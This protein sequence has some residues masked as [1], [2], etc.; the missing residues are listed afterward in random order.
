MPHVHFLLSALLTLCGMACVAALLVRKKRIIASPILYKAAIG[1]TL[2]T[3]LILPVGGFPGYILLDA[4]QI[5]WAVLFTL[6]CAGTLL[7]EKATSSGPDRTAL[8]APPLLVGVYWV[9]AGVGYA[10]GLAGNL[11]AMDTFVM[12]SPFRLAS[13]VQSVGL[14]ILAAVLLLCGALFAKRNA[15]FLQACLRLAVADFT[16]CLFLSAHIRLSLP[17]DQAFVAGY[18]THFGLLAM[19]LLAQFWL[20]LLPI[21]MRLTVPLLAVGTVLCLPG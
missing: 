1:C 7:S 3:F 10:Q 12:A 8:L 16:V 19:V 21:R 14:C 18:I 4:P 13:P 15:S 17:N 5:A 6:G 9:V 11:W 20:G 2:C